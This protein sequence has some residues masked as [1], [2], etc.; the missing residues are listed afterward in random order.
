V[1]PHF[2]AIASAAVA[3]N[4]APHSALFSDATPPARFQHDRTITLEFAQGSD[5]TR[6]CQGRFGVPPAG[7]KTNA[8]YTGTRAIMPNPC[9]FPQTDGYAHML[10]HELGHANGWPRTHGD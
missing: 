8:C 9:T 7:Y 5:I 2:L 3:I 10:C 6:E 1:S 4:L